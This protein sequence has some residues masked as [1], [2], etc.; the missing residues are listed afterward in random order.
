MKPTTDQ[1]LGV[2]LA[3]TWR[4]DDLIGSGGMASVFSATHQRNRLRVAVKL[5][6]PELGRNEP[7][8]HRFLREG[9]LANHIQHPGVVQVL[10]DGVDGDHVFLVMELLRGQTLKE[11]WQKRGRCVPP[12]QVETFLG[13]ILDVLVVA[14]EVGVVHRDLKPDNVFVQEDGSIKLLDCGIA[15]LHEEQA[16]AEHATATGTMLGTPA[17]MPPEQALGRWHE[18]DARSDLFAVGATAWLLLTGRFVHEASSIPE[19]LVATAT[20]KARALH[21]VAPAVPE[22]LAAAIDGALK[23]SR[24]DRWPDARAMLDVLRGELPASTVLMATPRPQ[25]ATTAFKAV[26]MQ[27]TAPPLPDMR[28]SE[29]S[30]LAI[31]GADSTGH[32]RGERAFGAAFGEGVAPTVKLDVS[33]VPPGPPGAL[34]AGTWPSRIGV[35]GG[36]AAGAPTMAGF[37]AASNPFATPPPPPD[38]RG[39]STHSALTADGTQASPARGKSRL[40]A[41]AVAAAALVAGVAVALVL[42]RGADPPRPAST[43][44]TELATPSATPAIT[45]APPLASA[46]PE[47]VPSATPPEPAPSA[48][49]PEV[50]PSA[51]AAA[52]SSAV[53]PASAAPPPPAPVYRSVCNVGIDGNPVCKKVRVR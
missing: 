29:A 40:I 32:V 33:A 23:F 53:P 16:L 35:V 49:R 6:H 41:A 11:V 13:R 42:Q 17:F 20:R 51:A 39:M 7:V 31:A 43:A 24:D 52:S 15:R 36:G 50:S 9:Y 14:H 10:D 26:P 48:A 47:M 34:E 1:R 18:V 12:D 3:G 30:G 38:P 5:L 28:R 37:G 45:A 27:Y 25:A 4:L 22:R 19:L 8:K 21:E 44:I 2:V 46:L